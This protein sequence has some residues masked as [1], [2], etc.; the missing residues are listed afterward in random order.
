MARRDT[1][2]PE[3]VSSSRSSTKHRNQVLAQQQKEFL[4]KYIHSNGPQDFPVKDPLDFS[5]WTEEQLRKYRELYLNPSQI[6]TPDVKTL[7]GYMLEGSELG[8]SSESYAKNEL[9]SG[10]NMYEYRNRDDLRH[11]V[12]DHFNN[13]LTVKESDVIMGF[14]YRVKNENKKFKM[15]FDRRN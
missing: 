14:I 5:S 6:I 12:E 7:Q 15:Y 9:S 10:T 8:E 2:E 1:S 11:A 13:Q 4:A 3:Q